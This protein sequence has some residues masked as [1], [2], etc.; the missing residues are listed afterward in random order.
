MTDVE[1]GLSVP[2]GQGGPR[3][4]IGVCT[5]SLPPRYAA[6]HLTPRN[7]LDALGWSEGIVP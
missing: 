4:V 3:V 1:G 5:R 7:A 6:R 2:R